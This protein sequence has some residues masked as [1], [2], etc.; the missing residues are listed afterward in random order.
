MTLLNTLICLACSFIT[1]IHPCDTAPLLPTC[2]SNTQCPSSNP[3]Q[4]NLP[5]GP[6]LGT[7]T[8][9]SAQ[10]FTLPYAQPPVGPLRFASPQPLTSF[11]TSGVY[12]ATHL[13]PACMQSPDSRYN[14]D[15][16]SEDC[17]YLNIYRPAPSSGSGSKPV[18]V[19]LHG[20]S[21]V[22]GSAAAPGL[23]GSYL[24][25]QNNVIVVTIQYRLGMFGFFSPS[26]STD[27]ASTS[28]EKVQG[29]QG[30][31]D[32]IQALQFIK[33]NIAAFDGNPNVVT[34]A[35]QSSGAHLIRSLLNSPSASPLFAGAILH[36]D[37]A[38]FGT[39]TL[40]TSH[41]VS[42][43]AM[44]QAGCSD[45][46]C[47]RGLS[48][49]EVL[50][51]SSATAQAGQGIDE[52]VAVSEVF[53]PFL[54]SLTGS[55]FEASPGASGKPIIVTNVENEAGS[56]VRQ[57]FLPT[58]PG[59]DS[60]QLRAYPISL[61][62]DQLLEQMFNGGRASALSSAA[63]Y[64]ME[65]N[66]SAYPPGARVQPY[67][68]ANDGLRR[69]LETI[70]AQGM[71]TCPTWFNALRHSSNAFIAL[72]ERGITYPSNAG[73]DYCNE[74]GR[75]CHEDDIQLVFTDPNK[76]AAEVARTV[77]EVQARW[78]AFVRSGNPNTSKY[79]GWT[80]AGRNTGVSA[81][82]M[83]LGIYGGGSGGSMLDTIS[84]QAGQYAGCGQVWGGEIKFDWQMYG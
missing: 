12:D 46:A 45:L 25:S 84:L 69:N 67:S 71:F 1:C 56:T 27:E 10:R 48:A 63:Q 40:T 43:F 54:G 17:L 9:Y 32:A 28:R 51:A 35:G 29:N 37:P 8:S 36:S 75:I 26:G 30:V 78:I 77:R 66:T 52:A 62:R 83:R 42:Q 58:S 11:N 34:L 41:G 24:A 65:T 3:L 7:S 57:M 31:R 5:L 20:G 14:I 6:V 68:N 38:N 61:P 81:K 64:G 74:E 18:L 47:L 19:W 55:A 53:R 72:F 73:N 50:D 82:V 70:L 49:E 23:D 80:T 16:V 13:P 79:R 33:S 44:E 39:Q 2:S 59:A 4:V 76:V 22:S 21:F 60:A 15:N